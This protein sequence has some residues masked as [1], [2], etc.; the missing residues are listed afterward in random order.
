MVTSAGVC[1]ANV[2]GEEALLINLKPRQERQITVQARQQ[3]PANVL[4]E[5]A[6]LT[7]LTMW[8]G[9]PGALLKKWEGA[10][11]LNFRP[12]WPIFMAFHC[13]FCWL[14]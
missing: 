14:F 13:F 1:L 9:E 10:F 8:A 6:L 11:L 3:W 5:E 7:R 2:L 12:L 4:S